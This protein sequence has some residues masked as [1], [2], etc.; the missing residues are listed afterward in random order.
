MPTYEY[1]CESCGYCFE[2]FQPITAKPLRKCPKCGKMKLNR[3]IGT[4][5]GILFKGDGFYQTDY[6]SEG[7]KQAKKKEGDS[8]S[9]A[10]DKGSEKKEAKESAS[11]EKTGSKSKAAGNSKKDASS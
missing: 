8:T 10:K 5:A 2:R 4:G 3:L 1:A 11:I 6:R 7:Y 9:G